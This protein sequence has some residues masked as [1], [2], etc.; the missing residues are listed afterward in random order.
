MEQTNEYILQGWHIVGFVF[1]F[2]AGGLFTTNLLI[3]FAKKAM[4]EVEA[5]E[6]KDKANGGDV[7]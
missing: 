2:L 6:K 4:K 1:S 7:E 3:P 5:M